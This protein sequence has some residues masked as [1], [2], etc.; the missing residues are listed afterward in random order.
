MDEQ[1]VPG[2]QGDHQRV[3]PDRFGDDAITDVGG[4][5]ESDAEVAR[6]QAAQL[7]GQRHFGHPYLDLGSSARQRARNADSRGSSAPSDT[8]M[9]RLPRKPAA[10]ALTFSRA[11]SRTVNSRRVSLQEHGTRSGQSV[12]GGPGRRAQRLTRPQAP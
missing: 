7:L 1:C 6:A 3:L 4:M 2:W 9:R 12:P 10:T 11:C 8:A 5:S